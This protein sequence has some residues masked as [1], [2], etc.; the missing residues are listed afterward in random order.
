MIRQT[1]YPDEVLKPVVVL[2]V[3]HERRAPGAGFA[4][5]GSEYDY[6]K[7]VALLAEEIAAKSPVLNLKVLYRDGIGISGVY[8]QAQKLKPDACIELHFNAFNRQASGTETLCS[9]EAQDKELALMVQKMCCEVFERK[10]L[11]RGVKVLPRS[12]RGGQ[13][14]YALPGFANCL[15]EPFFGDNLNEARLAQAKLP[16]YAVGLVSV[17]ESWCTKMFK[18]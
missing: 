10:D 12:A 1:P 3:G 9:V 7:K 17:L 5:G 8:K 2:I 18:A 4:L 15:V 13:N 11:S 14:I 6:N 16:T